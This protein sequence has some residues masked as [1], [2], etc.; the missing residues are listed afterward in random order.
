MDFKIVERQLT[1]L[2]KSDCDIKE[3]ELLVSDFYST[4]PIPIVGITPPFLCRARINK[5][6]EIFNHKEQL[7]YNP[8]ITKIPL[9]RGNYR[10]QQAFYGA[11]P[12]ME[13]KHDIG[14][15]QNTA[16]LETIWEHV[17][18]INVDRQYLTLSRWPVKRT[19]NICMLGF[20]PESWDKNPDFKR[21][22]EFHKGLLIRQGKK[23]IEKY[24]QGLEYISNIFCKKDDKKYCYRIS[25]A[26]FNFVQRALAAN[27]ISFDGLVYPSANT[28]AA[29]MNI[30]LKKDIIDDGSVELDRVIM[31]VM[32]RDPV[33]PKHISFPVV[34][35]EQTPDKDGR[36][37]F[38]HIW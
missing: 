1:E 2:S 38:K 35:D 32:Q 25:A 6:G 7:S 22:A 10:G 28:G 24:L 4:M 5:E 21:V 31:T 12:T 23:D 14:H 33:N 3:V 34:R 19:L 30:V 16:M 15:C 8:D 11:V 29:G 26:Y 18:D 20:A 36:F 27:N 37:F 9:Q 17:T 13:S